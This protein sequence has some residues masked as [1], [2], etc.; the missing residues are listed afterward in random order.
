MQGASRAAFRAARDKL[1]EAVRDAPAA[2]AVS[3]EL[4]QITG[5]LDREPALRRALTDVSRPRGA[6]AGLVRGLLGGRVSRAVLDLVADMAADRWSAPRDFPDTTEQL[7]VLATAAWADCEDQL[8]ELQDELFRFGRIMAGEPELQAALNSPVLPAERK[9]GLLDALLGGK[10]SPPSQRLIA[11]AAV[12]PR[13]RSLEANLGQ[14]AILAAEWQ[15]R[16][17]ALVRVATELTSEQRSRLAAALAA[18]YDRTVHLNVV[19]DPRVVGGISIQIGDDLIDG[20][21]ASRLAE[22]RRRLAA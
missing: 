6:R 17:I 8:E 22:L 21:V 5:L 4:F 10:A 13:G 1:A 2:A 3:D 20:S 18:M 12:Q 9:R 16:M 7:A 19:V 14:Y 15:R 11:Q